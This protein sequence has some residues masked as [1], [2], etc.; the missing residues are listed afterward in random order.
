MNSD[1]PQ[2]LRKETGIRLYHIMEALDISCRQLKEM[3]NL[4]SVQ[5]IYRWL[6]GD[7]MPSLDNLYAMSRFFGTDIECLIAGTHPVRSY[8]IGWLRFTAY[9]KR[10]AWGV[11]ENIQ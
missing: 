2:I 1:F 4:A 6:N 3:L 5:A 10:C 8:G 9:R 7:N 11:P